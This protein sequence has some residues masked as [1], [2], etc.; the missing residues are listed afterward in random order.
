MSVVN[1]T[2]SPLVLAPARAR[3]PVA[4]PRCDA[5]VGRSTLGSRRLV[6]C[7]LGPFEPS[8]NLAGAHWL[9]ARSGEPDRPD[10]RTGFAFANTSELGETSQSSI[11]IRQSSIQRQFRDA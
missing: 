1:R 6:Q 11:V 9:L 5:V 7:S 4:G 2:P 3:A 10:L 8:L